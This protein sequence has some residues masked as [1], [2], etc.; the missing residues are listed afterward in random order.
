M[1]IKEELL[2][3]YCDRI[4]DFQHI[5][6]ACKESNISGPLLISPNEKYAKQPFPFLAVGQETNGWRTF[7]DIVSEEECK[8]MMSEYEDFNVCEKSYP[9]PFWNFI[10]KIEKAL[11]N[12]SCSCAFSNISKYDYEN[13]RP[14]AIHEK[15]FSVVDSLL[16][17]EIN[18]VKPKICLFFTSY[19]FDYRLKNIFEQIEFIETGAFDIYK[20]CRLKHPNLPALSFRTYHPGFLQRCGMKESVINFIRS[21][22]E[23]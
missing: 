11:G 2:K 9:S 3:V 13:G 4:A 10:R 17:E 1:N 21:Q 5:Q 20:L 14:D 23:K 15:I 12:E 16:L 8:K 18:I 6:D 19:Q 7:T 22:I